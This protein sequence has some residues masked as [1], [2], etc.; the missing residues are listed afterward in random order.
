MSAAKRDV[1]QGMHCQ[2]TSASGGRGFVPDPHHVVRSSRS[3]PYPRDLPEPRS[4]VEGESPLLRTDNS[5]RRRAAR[6]NAPRAGGIIAIGETLT[7]ACDEKTA[8]RILKLVETFEDHDDV[9][10][11]HTN[12]DIPEEVMAKL[13]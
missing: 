11:V 7:V 12:A 8:E 5:A 6:E 3:R 9:Q 1:G 2:Y 13:A 4:G 10:K